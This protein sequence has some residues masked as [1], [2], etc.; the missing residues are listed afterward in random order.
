L[1]SQANVEAYYGHMKEVRSFVQLSVDAALSKGEKE[2]AAGHEAGLSQTEVEFGNIVQTKKEIGH[3]LARTSNRDLS[4]LSSLV[5]ARA[6]DTARAEKTAAE[7]AKE[8]PEDTII[9]RVKL[10]T[11]RAAIELQRNNPESAIEYRQN[12]A[13]Y[14]MGSEDNLYSA[15]LRGLAYLRL[16]RGAEAAVEF[17]KTLDHR[18]IL[19]KNGRVAAAELELARAYALQG[20]S[21]KARNTYLDFLTLWK[22]A[23][24]DIPLLVQAKGE[25]AKLK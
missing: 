16:K 11:I 23:D 17:P 8:F 14:E 20:D 2:P 12:T 24:P 13:R 3:A 18:A 7:L 21:A 15:Y 22:D 4:I 9:S 25:Y 5:L 1:E 10:P 19:Q 6:G